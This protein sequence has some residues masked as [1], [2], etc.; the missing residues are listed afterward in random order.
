MAKLLRELPIEVPAE[1]VE[2]GSILDN[3]T[4]P[5]AIPMAH[6]EGALVRAIRPPPERGGD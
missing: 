5:Q 2:R 1:L 6:P 3:Y 4:C